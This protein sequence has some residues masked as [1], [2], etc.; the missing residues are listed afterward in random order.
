MSLDEDKN[1][2]TCPNHSVKSGYQ[3]GSDKLSLH[4]I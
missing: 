3:N 2:I 4:D 1:I